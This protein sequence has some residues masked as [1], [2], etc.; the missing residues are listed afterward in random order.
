M[1]DSLEGY[2]DNI[3]AADT[4]TA[5]KGVPLAELEASLAISV[6]TVARQQQEI[7][8]LSKQANALKNRGMQAASV[9]TLPGGTTVCTYCEAV[10]QTAPHREKLLLL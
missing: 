10:V 5:S 4:Q 9:G 7:K 8:R 3:S 6:D 1:M 2:L